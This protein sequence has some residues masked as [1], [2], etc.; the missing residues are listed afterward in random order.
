VV[1]YELELKAGK[2]LV[3]AHGSAELVER[4]RVALGTTG[5]TQ[6]THHAAS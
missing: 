4:A 1:Q 2:F 3:L 5:A 6:L